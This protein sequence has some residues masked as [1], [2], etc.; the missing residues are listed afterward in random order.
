MAYGEF[1]RFLTTGGY[2]TFRYYRNASQVEAIDIDR[3]VHPC[4]VSYAGKHKLVRLRLSDGEQLLCQPGDFIMVCPEEDPKGKG[5]AEPNVKAE[6]AKGRCLK[7]F[8]GA[9]ISVVSVEDAGVQH[10]YTYV[11][12]GPKRS[13]GIVEDIIVKL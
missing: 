3:Q 10:C 8:S 7:T 12:S 4:T 13:W 2:Q 11:H 6:H 1:M 9:S 5:G